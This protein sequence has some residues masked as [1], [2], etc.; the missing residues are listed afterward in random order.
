MDMNKICDAFHDATHHE[1]VLVV[2]T[3]LGRSLCE[4]LH[5]PEEQT[6][7]VCLSIYAGLLQGIQD[8]EALIKSLSSETSSS[9]RGLRSGLCRDISSPCS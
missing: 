7:A 3:L 8:A 5:A 4:K 1:V 6:K 9:S 2:S